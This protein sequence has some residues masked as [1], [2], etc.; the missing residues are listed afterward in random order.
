MLSHLR[1]AS[2]LC[3]KGKQH[4]P[5]CEAAERGVP[6]GAI[7]FALRILM[8]NWVISWSLLLLLLLPFYIISRTTEWSLNVYWGEF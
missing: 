1:L 2:L 8:E 4:S 7:L 3:D 5:R 6:S